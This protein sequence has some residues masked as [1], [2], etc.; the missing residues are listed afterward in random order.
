MRKI[1]IFMILGFFGFILFARY[2]V[3]TEMGEGFDYFSI[4]DDVFG[5]FEWISEK[6]KAIYD[7]IRNVGDWWSRLFGSG[8]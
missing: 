7:G 8:G 3:G 2:F 1:L 5:I 4:F 6:I